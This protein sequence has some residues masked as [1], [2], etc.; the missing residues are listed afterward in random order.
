ML[1][2]RLVLIPVG[3]VLVL[4]G[5]F[6]YLWGSFGAFRLVLVPVALLLPV[7]KHGFFKASTGQHWYELSLM[8][9]KPKKSQY[10]TYVYVYIYIYIYNTLQ[11]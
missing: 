4:L 8:S 11:K 3:V 9:A 10:Y 6:W 2:R 7:G 1:V 5:Q